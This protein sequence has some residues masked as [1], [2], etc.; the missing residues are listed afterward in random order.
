MIETKAIKPLVRLMRGGK[1]KNQVGNIRNE[2]NNINTN[3]TSE[4][5]SW[6]SGNVSD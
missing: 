4:V 2:R 5:P 3:S 1:G 6:R